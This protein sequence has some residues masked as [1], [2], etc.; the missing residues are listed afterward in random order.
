MKA[1][2]TAGITNRCQ[3]LYSHDAIHKQVSET[4]LFPCLA[5]GMSYTDYGR[6]F[7]N[8]CKKNYCELC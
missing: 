4:V 5:V 3:Y 6:E 1:Q 2:D 7:E 8:C